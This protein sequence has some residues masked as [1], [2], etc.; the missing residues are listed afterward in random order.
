VNRDGRHLLTTKLDHNRM[1][2]DRTATESRCGVIPSQRP[3]A[4]TRT[5]LTSEGL[6]THAH[7]QAGNAGGPT[8]SRNQVPAEPPPTRCYASSEA[9]AMCSPS[10]GATGRSPQQVEQRT[11]WPHLLRQTLQ[12][13]SGLPRCQKLRKPRIDD[14]PIPSPP[15]VKVR[16]NH[17]SPSAWASSGEGVDVTDP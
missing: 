10:V 4:T 3:Y 13:Q 5:R 1:P 15:A 14:Q 6:D 11:A 17:Y 2:S 16:P 8:A 12:G 7:L 9:P